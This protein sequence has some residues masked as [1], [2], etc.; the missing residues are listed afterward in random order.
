MNKIKGAVGAVAAMGLYALTGTA[1]AATVSCSADNSTVTVGPALACVAVA[2]SNDSL[3]AVQGL[4]FGAYGSFGDSAYLDKDNRSE[5]VMLNNENNTAPGI[6]ENAFYSTTSADNLSGTFTIDLSL[7][8]GWKNFI[9]FIKPGNDGIY[10]L[11]DTSEAVAN[12]INGTY[13]I[14]FSGWS[15]NPGV[16]N[17]ISHISLYGSPCAQTDPECGPRTDVPEPGT[18]ALL[19]LGLLGLGGIRG[20]RSR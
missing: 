8:A 15:G 18:L 7:L 4:T 19:G 14:T 6:S 1:G 5:D 20:R 13:T 17:G 10:F 11:I 9:V 16:P 3:A 2:N 12:A